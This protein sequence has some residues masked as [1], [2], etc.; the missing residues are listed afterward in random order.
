MAVVVLVV[1]EQ[2]E[3][4]SKVRPC[5]SRAPA[6]VTE[7][8]LPREPLKEAPH[9]PLAPK[10]GGFLTRSCAALIVILGCDVKCRKS[11]K[12]R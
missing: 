5:R 12:D 7:K 6:L 3:R 11:W 2:Q 8:A 9:A 4:P 10:P 1:S